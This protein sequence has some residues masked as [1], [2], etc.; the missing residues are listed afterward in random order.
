MNGA[1]EGYGCKVIKT[2]FIFIIYRPSPFI[3]AQEILKKFVQWRQLGPL[4]EYT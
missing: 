2:P 1:N 3:K 4:G